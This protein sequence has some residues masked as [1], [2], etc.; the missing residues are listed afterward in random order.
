LKKKGKEADGI[1][2]E[3]RKKRVKLGDADIGDNFKKRADE[4]AEIKGRI[5]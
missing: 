2:K 3:L 4:V 1:L 5:G